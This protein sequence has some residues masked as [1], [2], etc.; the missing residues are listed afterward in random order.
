[1][2]QTMHS[3]VANNKNP[4]NVGVMNKKGYS[5][6]LH[7]DASA[8]I[9][10]GNL[11]A[12]ASSSKHG[13]PPM[14]ASSSHNSLPHPSKQGCL[15]QNSELTTDGERMQSKGLNLKG[16]PRK[17]IID[18]GGKDIGKGKD[19]SKKQSPSPKKGKSS[20]TESKSS[21]VKHKSG[22]KSSKTSTEKDKRSRS[23]S[24]SPVRGKGDTGSLRGQSRKGDRWQSSS[25]QARDRRTAVHSRAR[26]PGRQDKVRD[27]DERIVKRGRRSPRREKEND[28]KGLDG[29]RNKS[30][31]VS[32]DVDLRTTIEHGPK[33]QKRD[34]RSGEPGPKPEGEPPYKKSKIGDPELDELVLM[35]VILFSGILEC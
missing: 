9:I 27:R 20:K 35:A 1:M 5:G 18:K 3:A 28:G 19:E 26:S 14:S 16:S 7:G 24:T 11:S 13:A 6:Q 29:G 33:I 22:G 2:P 15:N 17:G 21:D 25:L 34:G 32:R 12:N 23:K 8:T 4:A 30:A 10:P 31:S